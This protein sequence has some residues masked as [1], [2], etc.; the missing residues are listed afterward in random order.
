MTRFLSF[1]LFGN[2]P[3][4]L[5]ACVAHS[6]SL[7]FCIDSKEFLSSFVVPPIIDWMLYWQNGCLQFDSN[8]ASLTLTHILWICRANSSTPSVSS[9]HT[10]RLQLHDIASVEFQSQF[11]GTYS[12][13]ERVWDEDDDRIIGFRIY[14]LLPFSFCRF[15]SAFHWRNRFGIISFITQLSER[16][17]RRRH[18]ESEQEMVGER[19]HRCACHRNA[20]ER[21][22]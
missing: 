4:S 15:C 21:R 7:A 16:N 13:I 11:C 22:Q 20:L 6:I 2:A 8:N 3:H 1:N 12:V 10:C 18:K 9:E 14:T 17:F 19:Y 5:F